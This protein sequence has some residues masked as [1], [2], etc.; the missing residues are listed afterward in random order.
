MN[1][2]QRREGGKWSIPT[3]DQ[4]QRKALWSLAWTSVLLVLLAVHVV[5]V[6]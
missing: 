1:S 4:H 3:P 2:G 6:I 5:W